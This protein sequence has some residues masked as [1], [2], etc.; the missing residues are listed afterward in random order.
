MAALADAKHD[1]AEA[2]RLKVVSQTELRVLSN[3]LG[4]L[5]RSA[6][7]VERKIAVAQDVAEVSQQYRALGARLSSYVTDLKALQEKRKKR[8]RNDE[9]AIMKILMKLD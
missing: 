7:S 2:R 9:D 1:L 5:T 6:K 3:R 4:G 8:M